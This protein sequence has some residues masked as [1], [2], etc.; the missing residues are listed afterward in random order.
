LLS[1]FLTRTAR[2]DFVL[3]RSLLHLLLAKKGVA[4]SGI[5]NMNLIE[6]IWLSLVEVASML[7]GLGRLCIGLFSYPSKIAVVV[8]RAF[9]AGG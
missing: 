5:V 6:A 1:I 7:T 3:V 4:G 2:A 9:I 8:K